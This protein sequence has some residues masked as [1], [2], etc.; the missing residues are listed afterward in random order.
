MTL[1]PALYI[2]LA[3]D[4][5]VQSLSNIYLAGTERAYCESQCVSVCGDLHSGVVVCVY[6]LVF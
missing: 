1:S 4:F 5:V 6:L 2:C 3:H